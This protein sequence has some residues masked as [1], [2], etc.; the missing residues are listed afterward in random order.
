MVKGKIV[1]KV[2]AS[3]L[4]SSALSPVIPEPIH[5]EPKTLVSVEPI[6]EELPPP[7]S[8]VLPEHK[9]KAEKTAKSKAKAPAKPVFPTEGKINKYGFLHFSQGVME[10]MELEKGVDYPVKI[11]GYKDGILTVGLE[12]ANK[13]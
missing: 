11:L 3:E 4:K 1:D 12:L 10:A 7:E 9:A 13:V 6:T 2:K 5:T 8:P